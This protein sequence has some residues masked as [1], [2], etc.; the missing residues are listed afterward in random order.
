MKKHFVLFVRV[1]VLVYFL[2]GCGAGGGVSTVDNGLT[3]GDNDQNNTNPPPAINSKVAKIKIKEDEIYKLTFADLNA[4][5][6]NLSGVSAA[7]LKMTSNGDEIAIDVIDTNKNDIFDEGDFIEFYGKAIP[8]GDN[9]FR[10]TETNVYW[11][12]SADGSGKRM[13]TISS[14][15]SSGQ[16]APTF[17]KVLHNEEDSWYEQKSLSKTG[18]SEHWF[19]GE[20]FYTPGAAGNVNTSYYRRDYNFITYGIDKNQPVILRL[21]LQSIN[22]SHHIRGYLNSSIN[23]NPIIDKLWEPD[24]SNSLLT[25]EVPIDPALLNNGS[26][27][28]RLESLG[29][30]SSGAYELFYMDWFDV[31]FY[32]TYQAEHSK[33]EFTGSGLI[34]ISNFNSS[35]IAIYDITD[36]LDVKKLTPSLIEYSGSGYKAE[37]S[38]PD[39]QANKFVALTSSTKKKPLSVEPYTNADISLAKDYDYI[40]VTYNDFADAVKPLADYRSNQG[41]KVLTVKIGDIY[42]EFSY[43]VET[44]QAIKDFLGSAYKNWS[45][46]PEFVLLIGDATLDYKDISGYGKNNGVK[47][48]VPAYLYDYPVLGEVPSDNWFVDVEGD[49][50]PEMKIGRIPAKTPSDVS[51]VIDKIISHEESVNKSKRVLLAA[52]D[53]LQVFE[54]LSNSIGKLIPVDYSVKELYQSSYAADFRKGIIDEINSGAAILNYTGHGSVVDWTKENAFS[55]QDTVYLTNKGSYPFVVALNCLNGYFVLPDDGV[56]GGES[57]IA[58]SFLLASERGAVAV[59]AASSIGYASEHDPLAKELYGDI[60]EDG[61]T[62]GEVVTR[63]KETA[64]NN[65]K[66]V[67]EDVVQTFIFFGDPATKLR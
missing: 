37:L 39:N 11:L 4:S 48:Y 17:P 47:S 20:A 63:A 18:V 46:K 43:G 25:I 33:L 8:R 5:F 58:E 22:G 31:E 67:P 13:D 41:Y 56:G 64:Y 15:A 52:D 34:D 23:P 61:I 14:S 54:T 59:F 16:G 6:V 3:G 35:N 19:W 21:R 50:L 28:F 44:P 57:S 10:Y 2:T 26:N 24:D 40:I 27:T 38:I 60:F 9:R 36:S 29:D 42:N 51:A 53:D 12:Y 1:L 45:V 65:G 7:S 55:S 49:V 30:T 62:L 66:G 32:H